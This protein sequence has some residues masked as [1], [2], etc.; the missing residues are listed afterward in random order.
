MVEH[1]S[2]LTYEHIMIITSLEETLVW[3][4]AFEKIDVA[5]GV[6]IQGYHA[7]NGIFAEHTF[8]S[9]IEGEK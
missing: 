9:S 7:D 6:K 5:F 8:R 2:D 4:A 3:K 1:F